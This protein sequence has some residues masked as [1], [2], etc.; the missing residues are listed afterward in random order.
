MKTD[1]T[2]RSLAALER[3]GSTNRVLNL[4]AVEQASR[5]DPEHASAPLF[6]D[7]RLNR[8]VVL[9]HRL[10]SDEVYLF[11][12][13]RASATKVIIPF[14]GK[15]LKLGGRSVFVGQ[16]GWLEMLKDL[17]GESADLERDIRLLE[18]LDGLPSL[19]P[20]LLREHL[21][22]NGYDVGQCYF[23]LSPA[24]LGR[25]RA[26]VAG[27]L[28]DL[29]DTAYRGVGG[30]SEASAARLVDALLS[31]DVD[32]RLEPLRL[33]LRLEGEA[34]REGIF[35]WRGLLYYKWTL[36]ALR[37]ALQRVGEELSALVVSG[38]ANAEVTVYIDAARRRLQRT[39]FDQVEDALSTLSAYDTA[40][41][42][43]TGKGEPQAF[44]RFLLQAPAMFT[45]L[46]E[47]V[48]AV[49]HIASFW[50]YRFPN[51][52][53]LRAPMEEAASM[54]HDFESGLGVSLRPAKRKRIAAP[55]R[56]QLLN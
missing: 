47:K 50:R 31:A 43:L 33:T 36:A 54:L 22:Q 34:W 55:A 35:S 41:G 42:E 17:C 6:H 8:S 4:L 56:I 38:S 24:D 29:I 51:G 30:A 52:R 21:R 48:G 14:E 10:R 5:G 1:R 16:R 7:R 11:D 23:S 13:W 53:P 19:D 37:P 46:G 12:G 20:F 15:E 27:E 18:R 2:H 39:I 44:V 32:D 28:S 49:S 26:F 9:K 25:M 40:F 3:S 45:E